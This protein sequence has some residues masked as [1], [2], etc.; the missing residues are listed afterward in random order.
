MNCQTAQNLL[1][2]Y[3]DCELDL[4]QKRELRNHLF[5]CT[6]CN[7]EYEQLSHLKSLMENIYQ[8]PAGFDPL[9][10]LYNRLETEKQSL[11]LP[12]TGRFFWNNRLLL[13]AACFAAFFLSTFMLFPATSQENMSIANKDKKLN[14]TDSYDQNFSIDQ[15]VN[16]YQASLILP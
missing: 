8:E 14:Y 2:A 9:S 4:E 15:S 11:L 6:E 5:I 3:I 16:V 12:Q 10:T 1:S 7:I 13:I